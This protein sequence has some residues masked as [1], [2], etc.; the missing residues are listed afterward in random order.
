MITGRSLVGVTA[1]ESLERMAELVDLPAFRKRQAAAR[2][3]GRYLGIGFATFIEAAPGP[4]EGGGGGVMGT[5]NMRMRLDAD[6]TVLGV[7][8]ARCRTGRAT[9]RRSPRSPPTRSACRSSRC[10]SSSA[11]ATARPFG[12][13]PAAAGPRRWPAAPRS[14]PRGRCKSGSS[15]SRPTCSRRAPS[16][17]EIADGKVAVRGRAR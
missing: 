9:R 8:G 4:N 14:T 6:G 7:H 13:A 16:D 1:R 2:A 12:L 10:G 11:T 17:L 3:E 15:T 5:E